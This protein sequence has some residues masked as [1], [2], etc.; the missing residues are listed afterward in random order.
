MDFT[1]DNVRCNTTPTGYFAGRVR[2]FI[3]WIGF[4]VKLYKNFTKLVR[5]SPNR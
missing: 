3:K 5:F 4:F 2:Y 1:F